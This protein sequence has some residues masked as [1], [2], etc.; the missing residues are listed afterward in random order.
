MSRPQG[1][2]AEASTSPEASAEAESVRAYD[3]NGN[4]RP[5]DSRYLPAQE[6]ADQ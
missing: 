2:K 6:E 4:V 1:R 5:A 3:E